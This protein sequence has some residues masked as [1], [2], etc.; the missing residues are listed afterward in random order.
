[1]DQGN[2]ATPDELQQAI[3]SI[4]NGGAATTASGAVDIVS[5]VENSVA[6][7]GSETASTPA[8]APVAEAV[9]AEQV[10]EREVHDEDT[11]NGHHQVL[12][13]GRPLGGWE[14]RIHRRGDEAA[15]EDAEDEA[16]SESRGV[17]QLLYAEL[18]LLGEFL[19]E[20]LYRYVEV[21]LHAN[22]HRDEG[23]PNHQEERDLLRPP[24]ARSE[25]LAAE[26]LRAHDD[27]DDEEHELRIFE[28]EPV[29]AVEHERD[30]AHGFFQRVH[31][32]LENFV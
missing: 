17:V 8:A 31:A 1:M 2:V 32:L 7:A 21:L 22:R 19:D 4:T 5:Q 25:E 29:H 11:G 3:N 13:A 12:K 28:Q 20:H 26:D 14:S 6:A 27:H 16:E 30:K 24:D 18:D 15:A 9:E 23:H 10:Q